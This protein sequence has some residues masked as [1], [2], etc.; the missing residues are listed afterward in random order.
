MA[1]LAAGSCQS[2][3]EPLLPD[4]IQNLE[5]KLNVVKEVPEVDAP[6]LLPEGGIKI[7]DVLI[8][9]NPACGFELYGD[10]IKSYMNGGVCN[11]CNAS[12]P[13]AV[14]SQ[15]V[16]ESEKISD[17]AESAMSE[18]SEQS[19]S[20]ASES[21]GGIRVRLC[22][23]PLSGF[24]FNLPTDIILGR[25][26]FKKTISDM[27]DDWAANIMPTIV[28]NNVDLP[29]IEWYAKSISRIS[30]EH[31]KISEDGVIED[32]GSVNST[33]L[34]REEVFGEGDSFELGMVLSIADELMLTRVH[35][36]KDGPGITITHTQTDISI[37]VPIG[38]KFHLGRLREDGRRE[39]FGFAITDHL[40]RMSGMDHDD[41]RRISR[42]HAFVELL[43][44][45]VWIGNIDGKPVHIKDWDG[46]VWELD[47]EKTSINV[48]YVLGVMDIN[49]AMITIGKMNF[50]ILTY[51]KDN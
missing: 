31:F 24:Q 1:D 46:N 17:E 29:S 12:D 32:M 30:R 11:Y 5:A 16:V 9:K 42:R 44:D 21:N 7:P 13:D 35:S 22:T 50:N 14:A 27:C 39:P 20:E 4:D 10:E 41:M 6:V 3:G 51:V 28:L 47:A 8:C 23:G 33:Y 37:D 2:C 19:E 36:E 38:K 26:F 43:D 40:K 18:S 34:D 48:G 49:D 25:E 15:P 45:G